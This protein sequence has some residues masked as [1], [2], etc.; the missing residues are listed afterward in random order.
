[1]QIASIT[2]TTSGA[3]YAAGP[4]Q[5]STANAAANPL[6]HHQLIPRNP[7]AAPLDPTKNATPTVTP[8][9]PV[10][11]TPRAPTPRR[12]VPAANAPQNRS[13]AAGLRPGLPRPRARPRSNTRPAAGHL[14]S[15]THAP[16]QSSGGG[17]SFRY[18]A[19]SM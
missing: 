15:R 2:S 18:W 14:L 5:D 10:P 19:R 12:T 3:G 4:G 6:A 7:A 11:G 13:P 9:L 8:F 16:A 17:F 1:M